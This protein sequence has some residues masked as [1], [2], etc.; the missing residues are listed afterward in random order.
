MQFVH[1]ANK[2]GGIPTDPKIAY[3]VHMTVE[4]WGV[5][6]GGIK[7]SSVIWEQ[8]LLLHHFLDELR[9]FF[10]TALRKIWY[11]TIQL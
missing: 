1:F 11:F 3:W 8:A 2:Q 7:I 6:S 5:K 4:I 10:D 9:Y